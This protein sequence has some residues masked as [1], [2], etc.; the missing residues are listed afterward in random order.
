MSPLQMI[1]AADVIKKIEEADKR[2][3]VHPDEREEN[4]RNI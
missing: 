4:G 3:N 2:K 1:P